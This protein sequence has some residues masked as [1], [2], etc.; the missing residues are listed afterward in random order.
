MFEVSRLFA[1]MCGRH[2]G[3]LKLTSKLLEECRR[4]SPLSC[5]VVIE[6]GY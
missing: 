4:L 2:A 5:D 6:M 1:R 3:V